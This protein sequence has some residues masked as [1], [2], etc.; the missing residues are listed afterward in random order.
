MHIATQRFLIFAQ[1]IDVQRRDRTFSGVFVN[2]LPDAFNKAVCAFYA[3]LLPFQSHI[4][5]RSEHHKQAYRVRAITFNHYLRVD[6]VIF[7]LGHFTHASVDQLMT[8][9]V[10]CFDNAAFFIALDDSVNWRNPVTFAVLA[11]IIERIRQYHALAQQLFSRLVRGDHARI[12]HQL[13]EEAEV[14]QVHD[15]MFN[16]ADVDVDRQPVVCRFRIQH[17]F[18]IL[19]AGVTR[20]VP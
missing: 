2:Q 6:T 14:E 5:R 19:R 17:S 7:R 3:G 8:R 12:A 9:C 13:M 20:V 16:T 18:L 15:G 11:D 4:R 10:F 1:R